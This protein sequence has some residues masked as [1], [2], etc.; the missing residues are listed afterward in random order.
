MLIL[1]SRMRQ[2][3]LAP[4]SRRLRLELKIKPVGLVYVI[5]YSVFL[6]LQRKSIVNLVGFRC[7]FNK[8]MCMDPF[9]FPT[10]SQLRKKRSRFIQI[11][12]K[13]YNT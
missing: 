8:Q 5:V 13:A 7:S 6:L 4:E 9:Q 10:D 12:K 1:I 2:L 11:P 3:D